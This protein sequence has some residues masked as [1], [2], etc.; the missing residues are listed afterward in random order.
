MIAEIFLGAGMRCGWVVPILWLIIIWIVA[1]KIIAAFKKQQEFD[2]RL[3]EI[4]RIYCEKQGN[5]LVGPFNRQ[6]AFGNEKKH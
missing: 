3:A 1:A 2:R 4:I 6:K 5:G